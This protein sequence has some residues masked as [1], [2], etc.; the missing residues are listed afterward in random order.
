MTK[1]T[2][3]DAILFSAGANAAHGMRRTNEDKRRAVLTLLNDPEWAGWS[4]REIARRCHV[5]H[6]LVAQLRPQLATGRSSSDRTYTTKHGSVSTMDTANIGRGR[7]ESGH[8]PD[9]EPAVESRR[10]AEADGEGKG[11]RGSEIRSPVR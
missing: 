11:G 5:G 8:G 7:T 1:S 6:P 3:R 4:D 9:A 10:A 2:R